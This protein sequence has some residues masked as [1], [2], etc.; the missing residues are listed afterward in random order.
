MRTSY[1]KNLSKSYTQWRAD[2]GLPSAEAYDM[3]DEREE[4]EVVETTRV[5]TERSLLWGLI[6]Y[7]VPVKEVIKYRIEKER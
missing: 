3:S 7:R 2:L 5:Y 6:K 1:P 4:Y